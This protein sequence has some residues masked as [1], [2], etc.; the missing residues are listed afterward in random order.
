[1]KSSSML[2]WLVAF[3]I[4]LAIVAASVGLF[5]QDDGTPST[6]TSL[7]GQTVQLYG[8]GLYRY[9]T[10]LI[11]AGNRG[12]DA[13]TLGFEIPLLILA[14]LF[15]RRGSIKAGLFLSA[16]LGWFLY[17]YASM[18]LYTAYNNLFLV[19]VALFSLSFFSFIVA[20]TSFDVQSFPKIF[21]GRYPH[22]A[23]T[24]YLFAMGV[25]FLIVWLGLSVL[26][27]T[28][29]GQAPSELATYSTLTTHALDLGI[30]AP[31]MF[32]AGIL[33]RRRAPLGY[34]LGTVMV[35]INV[36]IGVAL[37]G[38]GIAQ[39]VL[40]VPLPIGA[41]IGFMLSFAT[42]TLIAIS[43]TAVISRRIIT[44]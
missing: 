21:A 34:F 44:W 36:T 4:M 35:F 30:L 29:A 25:V 41:I 12:T 1:M 11:G 17:Y 15:Y 26:P 43:L 13:A 10:F 19:Y 7:R 32:I 6:I 31:T 27:A 3:I 16:A 23:M 22:R 37:I 20:L 2:G 33:L 8:Q 38:Q 14:F 18:A 40:Q 42:M 39:I 24:I 9:D 28:L 5:T